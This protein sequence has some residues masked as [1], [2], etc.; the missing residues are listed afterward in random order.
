MTFL[1]PPGIKGLKNQFKRIF[2]T[3][4]WLEK[5]LGLK[6]FPIFNIS[7]T[8]TKNVG[9]LFFCYIKTGNEWTVKYTRKQIPVRWIPLFSPYTCRSSRSEVFC[10]KD[11]LRNFA[12]FTGKH[13]MPA[14]LLKKRLWHRCFPVN[15]CEIS[16]KTFF[17][18]TPLA[19]ASNGNI[20][21]A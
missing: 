3:T 18:R 17:H 13:L 19:A 6:I 14:T 7:K 9:I 11:L 2:F 10:K 15:F 16:K 21:T 5:R 4:Y 12:K 8:I 1:S 20:R